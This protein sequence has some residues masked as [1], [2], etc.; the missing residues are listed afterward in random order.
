MRINA[1]LI[2]SRT[3]ELGIT[4]KAFAERTGVDLLQITPY[5]DTE[6][7]TVAFLGRVAELLGLSAAEL[8]EESGPWPYV[9]P[10]DL[11]M[12]AAVLK[13][14]FSNDP[15]DLA[16][17][18]GWPEYRLHAA[19]NVL[20]YNM[21]GANP[22]SAI[23]ASQAIA[24]ARQ[25][26]QSADRGVVFR[27]IQ[28]ADPT[29]SQAVALLHIIHGHLLKPV[30]GHGALTTR[31]SARALA[32]LGLACISD[33]HKTATSSLWMFGTQTEVAPH[34]DLLFALGLAGA[35]TPAHTPRDPHTG[36][37]RG[38]GGHGCAGGESERAAS[39]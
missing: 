34:P 12:V 15:G 28:P 9:V 38:P 27:A 14:C 24:L 3:V 30:L 16:L 2:R 22:Q 5:T 8:L 21:I 33:D 7:V 13:T 25:Q 17:R 32:E 39:L 10:G 37:T 11:R 29:P 31:N 4:E 1:G 6:Q 18:L 23:D 20:A 36:P 26:L 19:I 35:P